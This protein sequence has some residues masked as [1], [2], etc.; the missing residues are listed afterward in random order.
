MEKSFKPDMRKAL[1]RSL[2]LAGAALMVMPLFTNTASSMHTA[3][4][5]QRHNHT[6]TRKRKTPARFNKQWRAY[7]KHAKKSNRLNKRDYALRLYNRGILHD[8]EVQSTYGKLHPEMDFVLN[9]NLTRAQ[10]AAINAGKP[11][12]G[13][14]KEEAK[15]LRKLGIDNQRAAVH[16]AKALNRSKTGAITVPGG[17]SVSPSMMKAIKANKRIKGLT[18]QEQNALAEYNV[19]VANGQRPTE[20]NAKYNAQ[21]ISAPNNAKLNR[22]LRHHTKRHTSNKITTVP[23]YRN[24]SDINMNEAV[25]YAFAYKRGKRH[26]PKHYRAATTYIKAMTDSSGRR[27][28]RART[29]KAA[30]AIANRMETDIYNGGMSRAE[31]DRTTSKAQKG[32]KSSTASN[33]PINSSSL[34][35]SL[36]TSAPASN[37]PDI[38]PVNLLSGDQLAQSGAAAPTDI[39]VIFHKNGKN[40]EHI[41]PEV[42]YQQLENQRNSLAGQ[43]VTFNPAASLNNNKPTITFANDVITPSGS[44]SNVDSSSAAPSSYKAGMSTSSLTSAI[45]SLDSLEVDMVKSQSGLGSAKTSSIISDL[46][47]DEQNA[48]DELESAGSATT[49]ASKAPS[50]SAKSNSAKSATNSANSAV[51]KNNGAVASNMVNTKINN[52]VQ[53]TPGLTSGQKSSVSTYLQNHAG[54]A[55]SS[56]ASISS[57]G[58]STASDVK[59]FNSIA[60]VQSAGSSN[61]SKVSQSNQSASNANSNTDGLNNE[62]L[63]ALHDDYEQLTSQKNNVNAHDNRVTSISDLHGASLRKPYFVNGKAGM[64]SGPES[65]AGANQ[66]QSASQLKA[67]SRNKDPFSNTFMAY[68]VAHT[69][70]GDTLYHVI[71][72]DSNFCGWVD[73]KGIKG[74]GLENVKPTK[75]NAAVRKASHAGKRANPAFVSAYT[76]IAKQILYGNRK[77][78]ERT[79]VNR[80]GVTKAL[81]HMYTVKSTEYGN[82]ANRKAAKAIQNY[83]QRSMNIPRRESESNAQVKQ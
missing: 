82:A 77:F 6:T 74:V 23:S 57:A 49:L 26:S 18:K 28:L 72:Y 60:N 78:A 43:G 44:I 48:D 71:S 36:E 29:P 5:A 67:L 65:T 11:A 37:D 66:V 62:D 45:H 40:K 20:T 32:R 25:D 17:V 35:N 38:A 55:A 50:N 3:N 63:Q 69:S 41:I 9:H 31:Y 19:P 27:I 24:V 52:M 75:K 15:T 56:K 2:Y 54:S 39:D 83:V 79:K 10:K 22:K 64:F 42:F 7:N 53:N 80:H 59:K 61:A 12:K 21:T 47:S 73:A 14:T 4:A 68:Q 58:S 81:V 46:N 30:R 33:N 13:L 51:A 70:N 16:N 1:K 34:V 8:G 76:S